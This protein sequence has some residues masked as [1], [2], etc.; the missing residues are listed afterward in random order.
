MNSRELKQL[1]TTL[2]FLTECKLDVPKDLLV[3]LS[4]MLRQEESTRR[5]RHM[6]RMTEEQLERYD[7][8]RLCSVMVTTSDGRIIRSRTNALTF[9]CVL[10]EV[11][12][13][14]LAMMG[15]IMGSKPIVFHDPSMAKKRKSGYV[16]SRPGYFVY[17]ASSAR[18]I[19]E[20]L[21]IIDETLHLDLQ[22]QV[23]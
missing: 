14:R 1:R 6:D 11:G 16:L 7:H 21:T 2:R 15:F 23:V 8:R 12:L 18:E 19:A 22:I 5:Q 4:D 9:R 20:V 3:A 13:E 10:E 17:K